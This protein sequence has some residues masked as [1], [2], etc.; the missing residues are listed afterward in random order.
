MFSQHPVVCDM[1][2]CLS[3]HLANIWKFG[4]SSYVPIL[5]FLSLFFTIEIQLPQQLLTIPDETRT[6]FFQ[7]S[8]ACLA[9]KSQLSQQARCGTAKGKVSQ[10]QGDAADQCWSKHLFLLALHPALHAMLEMD[11]IALLWFKVCFTKHDF[12]CVDN[13]KTLSG[14]H[15]AVCWFNWSGVKRRKS[16]TLWR[17]WES[18]IHQ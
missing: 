17:L 3:K 12:T 2:Y 7:H 11:Q 10:D 6:A 5:S 13:E 4:K 9:L 18:K 14:M 1:R 15:I 16:R 8:C